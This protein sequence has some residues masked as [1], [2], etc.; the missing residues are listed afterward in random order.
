MA[1]NGIEGW[2]VGVCISGAI[3]IIVVSIFYALNQWR[4]S[5]QIEREQQEREQQ[6]RSK[7]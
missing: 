1:V 4:I 7:E 3:A 6:E 2:I 5:N